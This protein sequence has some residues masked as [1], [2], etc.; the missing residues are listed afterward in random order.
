V[1]GSIGA[2]SVSV[3]VSGIGTGLWSEAKLI[4]IGASQISLTCIKCLE[5]QRRNIYIDTNK[6]CK[7]AKRS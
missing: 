2:V 5:H 4:N 7:V 3:S 6:L 1:D